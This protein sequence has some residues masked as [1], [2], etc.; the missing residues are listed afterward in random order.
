MLVSM[1][2]AMMNGKQQIAFKKKENPRQAGTSS[3]NQKPITQQPN[4]Q[5][6]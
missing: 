2:V 4:L 6:D 1:T 5:N 3:S